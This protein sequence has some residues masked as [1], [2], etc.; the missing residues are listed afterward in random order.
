VFGCGGCCGEI[1]WLKEQ[2]LQGGLTGRSTAAGGTTGACC[3]S[4]STSRVASRSMLAC[5]TAAPA[6]S[7]A[8]GMLQD[9]Q[10]EIQQHAHRSSS[11]FGSTPNHWQDADPLPPSTGALSADYNMGIV[12]CRP[13]SCVCADC[14]PLPL[15]QRDRASSAGHL[16]RLCH[17]PLKGTLSA[18]SYS[19]TV[20]YHHALLSRIKL[21]EREDAML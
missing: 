1:R 3:G 13:S 20:L 6:E 19:A 11:R 5:N 16:Y 15:L 10:L 17:P 18:A 9:E 8:W 12:P 7:V 2:Q 4:L 14:A 21:L